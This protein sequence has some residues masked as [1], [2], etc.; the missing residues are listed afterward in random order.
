MQNDLD[1]HATAYKARKPGKKIYVR[2]RASWHDSFLSLFLNIYMYPESADIFPMKC[3]N[4]R[5]V[6]YFYLLK[7]T[8][9]QPTPGEPCQSRR[10]AIQGFIPFYCPNPHTPHSRNFKYCLKKTMSEQRYICVCVCVCWISFQENKIGA[11]WPEK[12]LPL[13]RCS[14]SA[15]NITAQNRAQIPQHA[16]KTAL[17]FIHTTNTPQSGD[18]ISFYRPNNERW[19][20]LLLFNAN[21]TK[22]AV[23]SRLTIARAKCMIIIYIYL[24]I[25]IKRG[26]NQR[27]ICSIFLKL[28]VQAD[29]RVKP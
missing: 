17:A 19:S 8:D 18:S 24:F 13:S 10:D 1:G 22:E 23:L 14:L 12:E 15:I 4:S 20:R 27:Q 9:V 29:T 11:E 6:L 5:G 3:R 16:H 7:H 26:I 28:G 21:E 2:E 25:L